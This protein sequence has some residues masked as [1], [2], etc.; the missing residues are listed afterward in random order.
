MFLTN[1]YQYRNIISIAIL[2]QQYSSIAVISPYYRRVHISTKQDLYR[3][4]HRHNDH[5]QQFYSENMVNFTRSRS[6]KVRAQGP[7]KFYRTW[8]RMDMEAMLNQEG[9]F[10]RVRASIRKHYISVDEFVDDFML[11]ATR[12]G[13]VW[14]DPLLKV[15]IPQMKGRKMCQ[16][17]LKHC[18]MKGDLLILGREGPRI[19]HHWCNKKY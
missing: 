13:F 18:W 16:L 8:C 5:H 3:T 6:R 15:I 19:T 2:Y 14:Q 1:Y 7:P 11:Y 9:C 17:L 4:Q 10:K 12:D